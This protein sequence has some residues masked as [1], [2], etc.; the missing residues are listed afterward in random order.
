MGVLAWDVQMQSVI[1]K[2][3]RRIGS[4]MSG[5]GSATDCLQT[6]ASKPSH[7]LFLLFTELGVQWQSFLSVNF[8]KLWF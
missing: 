4:F 1:L 3:P 2:R 7:N 6:W 8:D 5:S